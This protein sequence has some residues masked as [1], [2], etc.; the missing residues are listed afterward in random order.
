MIVNV[1]YCLMNEPPF[2]NPKKRIRQ[3]GLLMSNTFHVLLLRLHFFTEVDLSLT[4]VTCALARQKQTKRNIHS[5]MRGELVLLL[6]SLFVVPLLGVSPGQS[7]FR[8]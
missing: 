4:S 2:I 3:S 1:Y 6:I 5:A 7:N 8:L